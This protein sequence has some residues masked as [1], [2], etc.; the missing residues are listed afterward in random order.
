MHLVTLTDGVVYDNVR[1]TKG[2]WQGAAVVGSGADVS[3]VV[4]AAMPNGEMHLE[5]LAD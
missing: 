1:Y 4:T 5:T 3:Q 2:T